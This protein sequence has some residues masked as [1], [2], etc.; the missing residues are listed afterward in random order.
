MIFFVSGVGTWL[1]MRSRG[2]SFFRDRF[3]RLIIPFLFGALVIVPCQYYYQQL[4]QHPFTR[5]TEFMI[6]YPAFIANRKYGVNLFAW[7]LETGIHLWYLP[8]LFIMTLVTYPLLKRI[9]ATG[10]PETAIQKLTKRPGL[11]L[12]LALPVIITVILL[13][14]LFPDYTGV[15]DFF[16]YA[17]FFVYGFAF[18]R[19]HAR[20]LP[21]LNTNK[22]ILLL[23][24]IIS[25]LVLISFLLIDPL[26]K[27]AFH[28]TYNLAHLAVSIPLGLSAFSWSFYFVSL[29]SRRF[30]V[31]RPL[32]PELNRSVLPVYIIHQSIIVVAGYYI[33]KYVDPGFLEFVFIVLTTIALSALAFY[34]IKK[35]PATRFVFGVKG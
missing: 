29:F 17:F 31:S 30:N 15:A 6:H 25:S 24:G 23:L 13:Q 5:F 3:Q 16:T 1:A 9:D 28:P 8:Y 11:L 27:A 26:R 4:Q 18:I 2:G 10:V 34:V 21:I 22:T 7:I 20:L 32:L 33:I 35:F 19:E 14:P 12:L